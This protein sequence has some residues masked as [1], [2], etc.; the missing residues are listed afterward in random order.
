MSLI[1]KNPRRSGI[2]TDKSGEMLELASGGADRL[3]L[4]L[5]FRYNLESPVKRS[6]F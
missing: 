5:P 2:F 1:N 4:N 3:T 6:R